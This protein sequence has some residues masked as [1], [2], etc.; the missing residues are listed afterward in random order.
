MSYLLLGL[1]ATWDIWELI[2][3]D[4]VSD[5]L[6]AGNHWSS[7]FF[8][9]VLGKSQLRG[10]HV[11]RG[12]HQHK[13]PGPMLLQL[14]ECS[15]EGRRHTQPHTHCLGQSDAGAINMTIAFEVK[16]LN[17]E[18]SGAITLMWCFYAC[19]CMCT[20]VWNFSGGQSMH[21]KLHQKHLE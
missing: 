15:S 2:H 21:S 19:V 1:W 9:P 12:S 13:P 18:M 10:Q 3:C 5:K 8:F 14:S 20:G 16:V 11:E 7:V 6:L 17:C 4:T